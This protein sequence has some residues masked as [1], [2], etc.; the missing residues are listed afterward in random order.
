MQVACIRDTSREAQCTS[1]G[2]Q[3]FSPFSLNS[4]CQTPT[5]TLYLHLLLQPQTVHIK[6]ICTHYKVGP[7]KTSSEQVWHVLCGKTGSFFTRETKPHHGYYYKQCYF[8]IVLVPKTTTLWLQGRVQTKPKGRVPAQTSGRGQMRERR[9]LDSSEGA[10]T[11]Q[12]LIP[13]KSY[14]GIVLLARLWRQAQFFISQE[15]ESWQVCATQAF[16]FTSSGFSGSSQAQGFTSHEPSNTPPAQRTA[17][18][19]VPGK[20]FP[21]VCS[22]LLSRRTSCHN[23]L[24]LW[25]K[26]NPRRPNSAKHSAWPSPMLL[27]G[28]WHLPTSSSIPHITV[29]K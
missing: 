4:A 23:L 3:W 6:S 15:C 17:R 21:T 18:A 13:V 9:T 19:G 11:H 20:T 16:H 1:R 8:C 25:P 24:V 28:Y 26:P 12:Q 10:P 14:A 2:P 29:Q 7:S 22:R 5:Q 27:R